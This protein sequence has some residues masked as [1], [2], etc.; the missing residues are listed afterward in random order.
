[1]KLKLEHF[2]NHEDTELDIPDRGAVVFTG[3][4]GAGKSMLGEALTWCLW[5]ITLR[6]YRSGWS[7]VIPGSI[8]TV[9]LDGTVY[10]RTYTESGTRF[11]IDFAGSTR[12]N[13]HKV[14]ER[15][16]PFKEFAA[17][18]VFHRAL[19]SK[20]STAT[21]GERK[22]LM[23]SM[24]GLSVFDDCLQKVRIERKG[25][26][27]ELL[28]CESRLS[29][30]SSDVAYLRGSLDSLMPPVRPVKSEEVIEA[31]EV[32]CS[33]RCDPPS[34]NDLLAAKARI[35]GLFAEYKAVKKE[36]DKIKAL[37]GF[38]KCHVCGSEIGEKQEKALSCAYIDMEVLGVDYDEAEVKENAL[39]RDYDDA[40]GVYERD[41]R[42]KR[43]AASIVAV[44]DDAMNTYLL[45]KSV[46]AKERASLEERLL[47]ATAKL[48]SVRVDR[49]RLKKRKERLDDLAK[50]YGSKGARV[51]MLSRAFDVLSRVA[52]SVM[53]SI[54]SKPVS[55]VVQAS[56]KLDKVGFD[57]RIGEDSVPYKGL[58]EGEK[59]IMDFALLKALSCVSSE[60]TRC[61][62][63]PFIYDDILHAVDVEKRVLIAD[64][65]EN[66]A[67]EG[68][69]LIF[70]HD[71]TVEEL[72]P[73]AMFFS[74]DNGH[75]RSW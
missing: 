45:R 22:A 49:L 32:L 56:E 14:S 69:V 52:S 75:V 50:V 25:V 73:E 61:D 44:Y 2:G 65:I 58:S 64:F 38:G 10:E 17:T 30:A 60:G 15:F 47:D 54:Y 3:Q 62:A 5:G 71:E 24:I 68:S 12:D 74:V 20:F 43:R 28:Q 11:L 18:K 6:S 66:E 39:R 1:M 40:C 55:V 19:L 4:N 33:E 34:N 70:T 67:E 27:D 59:S 63:L 36:Y 8:V 26:V 72:F 29:S 51:L 37:V 53:R 35:A 57:V 23:E 21:D 7:P 13:N 41:S 9:E 31:S 16:G 42:R 48:N 46:Y